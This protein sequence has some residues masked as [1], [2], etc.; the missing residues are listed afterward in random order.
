M[1]SDGQ[2]KDQHACAGDVEVNKKNLKTFEVLEQYVIMQNV[3][4]Q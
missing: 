4:C 3:R 1:K 2:A